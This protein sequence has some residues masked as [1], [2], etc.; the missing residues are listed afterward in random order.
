MGLGAALFTRL[1][2]HRLRMEATF[3][4]RACWLNGPQPGGV[5][6]SAISP[7]KDK[8]HFSIFRYSPQPGPKGG[9]GIRI[10]TSTAFA[11]GRDRAAT[12][13]EGARH[14][15]STIP[16]MGLAT[17]DHLTGRP[18]AEHF[19]G[20]GRRGRGSSVRTGALGRPE[21][22]RALSPLPRIGRV[23]REDRAA[24]ID[25]GR[26]QAGTTL[27]DGTRSDGCSSGPLDDDR[28]AYPTSQARA[29]TPLRA[30]HLAVIDSAGRGK[31]ETDGDRSVYVDL[32]ESI[33][34]VAV[35]KKIFRSPMRSIRRRCT[36]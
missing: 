2:G 11:T 30:N 35:G 7:G 13:S 18:R 26:E 9:R 24:V 16:T 12:S 15:N 36:R 22:T 23:R 21:S 8:R 6:F 1:S 4:Y 28:R 20:L 19:R 31:S 32:T 10:I 5:G 27:F 14:D 29:G 33:I 34:E 3:A 25:G 17:K